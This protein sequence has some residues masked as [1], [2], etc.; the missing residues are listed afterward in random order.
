MAQSLCI[1]ITQPPHGSLW[2]AEGLRLASGSQAY[3]LV[4]TVCLLG[5]AVWVAKKGQRTEG[6]PWAS[7]LQAIATLQSLARI[8]PSSL[9]ILAT[10]EDLEE[11]GLAAHDLSPGVETAAEEELTEVVGRHDAVVCF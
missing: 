2:A 9:R 6:T 10:Q 7:L 1:L 3:G 5:D 11:R 4:T 8:G